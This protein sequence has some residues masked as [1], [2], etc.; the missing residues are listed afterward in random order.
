MFLKQENT[1]SRRPFLAKVPGH[2]FQ[3]LVCAGLPKLRGN[4][5]DVSKQF[6]S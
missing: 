1:R 6:I 2:Q 5:A 3:V 4:L